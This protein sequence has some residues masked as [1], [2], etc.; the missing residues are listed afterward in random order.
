MTPLVTTI[1]DGSEPTAPRPGSVQQQ[2]A[3][4]QQAAPPSA[5]DPTIIILFNEKTGP[6]QVATLISNK[7]SFI[8]TEVWETRDEQDRTAWVLVVVCETATAD[9]LF[10][11]IG[12]RLPDYIQPR[13]FPPSRLPLVRETGTRVG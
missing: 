3:P 5:Q 11:L 7:H 6:E 8:E 4:K 12:S 10:D 9:Q 1:D 2:P 13:R